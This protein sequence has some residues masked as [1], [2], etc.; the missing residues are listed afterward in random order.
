MSTNKDTKG[1]ELGQVE[2]VAFEKG[3]APPA[4]PD[5]AMIGAEKKIMSVSLSTLFS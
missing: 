2:D 3:A 1:A 5:A 4:E